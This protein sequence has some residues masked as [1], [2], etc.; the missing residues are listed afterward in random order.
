MNSFAIFRLPHADSCTM[1]EG[2]AVVVP[3][4]AELDDQQG[5]LI[6]PF[7][8]SEEEPIVLI[9]N[10]HC[11][12]DNHQYPIN[13]NHFPVNN[14]QQ[15]YHEDFSI[16]HKALTDGQFRKLVLARCATVGNDGKTTPMELFQRACQL[17]PRMFVALVSTPQSGMWLT[18][19]PEILLESLPQAGEVRGEHLPESRWRTIALAGTMR[20]RSDKAD[21][22]GQHLRWSA[23]NIQ[24]QRYV[25]SYLADVLRRFSDDV[26]EEGPRTVR[27]AHLVHLRSDFTF[28][29]DNKRCTR[30]GKLLEALH[31]TPAVCG[32]PK[33]E[34]QRFIISHEH[35][36]RHYY[37]GFMGPFNMNENK[38]E[39]FTPLSSHLTHLFVSLR[40]MHI[41]DSA[42]HLYA[43][44]G[45]LC[46]SNEQ[47]EWQE[48]EA[49]MDTMRRL[50]VTQ[51]SQ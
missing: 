21:D 43:G 48:T 16:F 24:E 44:G 13:N 51:S 30:V 1:I 17:Y 14:S 29:L 9:T 18:A 47:Q 35:S 4:L 2:D 42:Y 34:A 45:L 11:T 6:A 26:C 3:S 8:V 20:L 49:K 38:N 40:C 32:L 37:S 15:H 36:P 22:E 33:D 50:L 5:F 12:I 10:N 27:A 31:P 25:A 7:M 41:T 46:E 19:S 39:N 23:K 28:S